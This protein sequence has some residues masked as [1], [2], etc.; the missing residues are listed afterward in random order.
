MR[1]VSLCVAFALLAIAS[2]PVSLA[3]SFHHDD[4]QTKETIYQPEEVD[5][6]VK[7]TRKSEPRYTEQ[8][9][10]NHTNGYVVLRVVL[11]SSGEVGD[12][13]VIRGL[14]DGLTEECISSGQRHKI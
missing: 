12:I 8:A 14:E 2:D 1:I 11:K 7:I 13:T 4:K 10:R 6:R 3:G 5:R 9:R